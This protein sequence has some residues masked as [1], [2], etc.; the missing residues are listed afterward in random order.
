ML[1]D[2][3]IGLGVWS[4][5]AANQHG[6]IHMTVDPFT[7]ADKGMMKLTLRTRWSLTTLREQ[8]FA[9][10]KL[11]QA[12]DGE[13][14]INLNVHAKTIKVGETL[15]LAA[16]VLPKTAAVTYTSGTTAKATVTAAGLVEGKAVGSSVITASITVDGKSYTDTCT[17]TV[18]AAE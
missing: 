9:C 12:P 1:D 7:L 3:F 8:A 18:E 2:M 17:V 10:Y 4:Y 5:F 16:A 6:K 14:G 15:Q 11:I 13:A